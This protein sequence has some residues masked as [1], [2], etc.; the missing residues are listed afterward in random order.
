MTKFI[1]GEFESTGQRWKDDPA[2]SIADELLE[3][4]SEELGTDGPSETFGHPREGIV[5]RLIDDDDVSGQRHDHAEVTAR[6]SHDADSLSA[7]ESAMHLV[8]DDEDED[9][10]PP[11]DLSPAAEAELRN[12]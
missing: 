12:F 11:Q 2:N 9:D 10:R 3:E 6:D 8:E 5:G 4:F 7:E 1:N